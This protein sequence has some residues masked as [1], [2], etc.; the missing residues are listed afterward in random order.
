MKSFPYK[1]IIVT[2]S[3]I[4]GQNILNDGYHYKVRNTLND[5]GENWESIT[6]FGASILDKHLELNI[7]PSDSSKKINTRFIYQSNLLDL[8]LNCFNYF[9]LKNH[10]YAYINPILSAKS[11]NFQIDVSG[12]G[13]RNDWLQ[14]HIGK[15]RE[16]WA[17]GNDIQLGLSYKSNNYNYFKL[18]SDYGKIRVNYIHGFLESTSSEVNRYITARGIEWTNKN[19]L[20]IGLSETIIYSGHKRGIDIGY[21]NPISSHLEI[22]LNNRLNVV[23]NGNANAIWQVHLDYLIAKSTRLSANFLIDEFVFDR[24]IEVGKEHGSAYSLRIAYSPQLSSEKI[25]TFFSSLHRVGTPTF[26][27]LNGTNNFVLNSKPL[28]W[29]NGSDGKEINFGLNILYNKII[30][31]SFLLGSFSIGDESIINRPYETYENYGKGSFPSGNVKDFKHASLTL[32]WKIKSGMLF[33]QSLNIFN[34]SEKN[35]QVR[36]SLGFDFLFFN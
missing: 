3:M 11:T 35:K 31:I 13:Y 34:N 26:R 32:H 24:L 15:G 30:F 6:F 4:Y 14:L 36:L 28:G 17:S 8:K 2:I 9:N 27:H 12:F 16:N 18:A 23:G 33:N 5:I 25:L 29:Q 19:Y 20:L 22:E 21:F 1:I 7:T 10:F